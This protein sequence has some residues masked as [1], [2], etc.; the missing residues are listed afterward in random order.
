LSTDLY[1][2]GYFKAKEIEMRRLPI[3]LLVFAVVLAVGFLLPAQAA[4]TGKVVRFGTFS[5]ATDY[6]PYLI[7]KRMGWLDDTLGK[8]GYKAEY[9]DP[10]QSLAPINE[11]LATGAVD[12]V[13]AAEIPFII[14]RASGIDDRIVW[15][16]CATKIELLVPPSSTAKNL[17]DLKGKR[18]AGLPG[19][20]SH[21]GFMDNLRKAGL[22]RSAVIFL[23]MSPPESK[24]AFETGA[25]DA[26][27]TWPPFV[28]QEIIAGKGRP[29]EGFD[30]HV[31]VGMAGRTAFM[32]Q[33]PEATT[34]ILATL[35][36]ARNWIKANPEKAQTMMSEELKLPLE[37]VKLAWPRLDWS[38]SLDDKVIADIQEKADFLK[39]LG[40]IKKSVPVKSD[41]IGLPGKPSTPP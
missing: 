32:Q 9:L 19:T 35:D 26:W 39:D 1:N 7:A 21:F 38:G 27:V 31:Q 2:A 24:A 37:V 18:V 29:L 13:F 5:V 30:S 20:G 3:V 14:G 28:E 33:N 10:F 6:A 8:I 36:R 25:V 11:A 17:A 16:S 22:D 34:Q 12:F 4:D 15:Y 23:P 40:Q 41:L